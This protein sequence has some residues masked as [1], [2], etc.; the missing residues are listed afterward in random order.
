[1]MEKFETIEMKIPAKAEYVAIIRLTM[2]GV[3]NRMGF[4]YDDIEDMKIAISEACTNIVQ[5]AYKEDD[6]EITIIFG[7]YEDR[8]EIMVADNGVSFDFTALKSKVGPYDINKPV[9]NLPENG[10]GLY[11]INTLMDDIQIMHDE[12][13]T[14]LMTKYIQREQVENDGNPISTYESY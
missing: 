2:A 6:G 3:A 11:L 10:L 8:L 5:H 1:M 4:A 13:M 7:L 14:V 12:G 9:E